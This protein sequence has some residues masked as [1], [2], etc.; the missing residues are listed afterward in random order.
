MQFL[1]LLEDNWSLILL[2]MAIFLLVILYFEHRRWNMEWK[3]NKPSEFNPK[4]EYYFIYADY[5]K[6]WGNFLGDP[7]KIILLIQQ[8][9]LSYLESEYPNLVAKGY[10]RRGLGRIIPFLD[11]VRDPELK[12]FL[13]DPINWI[14]PHL[15]GKEKYFHSQDRDEIFRGLSALTSVFY[16][17]HKRLYEE[18]DSEIGEEWLQLKKYEKIFQRKLD[19]KRTLK[20]IKMGLMGITIILIMILAIYPFITLEAPIYVLITSVSVLIIF[21]TSLTGIFQKFVSKNILE[22]INKPKS[23]NDYSNEIKFK[24][25]L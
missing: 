8:N 24:G 2:W 1:Y 3:Y 11:Y 10:A 23:S 6:W 9:F 14:K 19:I 21:L 13:L 5:L 18:T 4:S 22:K 25:E 7:E 20:F 15:K 17:L 16:D 12:E